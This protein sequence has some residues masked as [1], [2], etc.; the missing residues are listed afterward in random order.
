MAGTDHGRYE[1]N[2]T[3]QAAYQERHGRAVGVGRDLQKAAGVVSLA[4]RDSETPHK[5]CWTLSHAFPHLAHLP[6][7]VASR[8]GRSLFGVVTGDSDFSELELDIQTRKG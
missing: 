5:I 1:A 6:A 8:S 4:S 7:D 3:I 2:E